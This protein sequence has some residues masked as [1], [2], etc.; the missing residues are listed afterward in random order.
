MGGT[1]EVRKVPMAGVMAFFV[2]SI[3]VEASHTHHHSG[4]IK[5]ST[6]RISTHQAHSAPSSHLRHVF[7]I[8]S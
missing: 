2:A 1:R 4:D 5:N 7:Y 8:G 3:R 6:D